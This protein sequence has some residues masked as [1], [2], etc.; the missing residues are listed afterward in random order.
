MKFDPN[1]NYSQIVG[2]G[3]ARW[4]QDGVYFDVNFEPIEEYVEQEM[5]P[6]VLKTTKPIAEPV[7][8]QRVV[9]NI[10]E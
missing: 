9:G 7:P 10:V 5:P 8:V 2:P 1:K 4:T 3:I 6:V